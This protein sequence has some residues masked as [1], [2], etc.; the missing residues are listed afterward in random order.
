RPI[1]LT[2]PPSVRGAGG[3]PGGHDDREMV[4]HLVDHLRL[5]PHPEGG[6]FRRTFTHHDVG[7][8]GRPLGSA[9]L[10]LLAVGERSHWHRIDAVEMWHF[11]AGDPLVLQM[12][13]DGRRGRTRILG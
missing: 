11:H 3:G 7:R 10:Y 6:W 8:D 9:I 5:A 2:V 4:R 12:S 13:P 1:G